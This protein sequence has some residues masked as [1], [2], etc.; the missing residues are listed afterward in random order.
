MKRF[1]KSSLSLLL[2]ITI[3]FSSAYVGLA[4]VDFNRES[5]YAGA[6]ELLFDV[7][8]I[9]AKLK[10][11]NL[12][13]SFSYQGF[14][15]IDFRG[16][17]KLGF[18]EGFAVKAKAADYSSLSPNEYMSKVILNY[19]YSGVLNEYGSLNRTPQQQII[20]DIYYIPSNASSARIFY[21]EFKNAEGFQ[22]TKFLYQALTFDPGNAVAQE[23]K[24][25][26][27]YSAIILSILDAKFQ[28]DNFIDSINCKTNKNILS[29]TKSV[30]NILKANS[31]YDVS[32]LSKIPISMLTED[33]VSY[34]AKELANSVN[35][36][37]LYKEIG[38]NL[39]WISDIIYAANSVNDA[40][41]SICAYTSLADTSVAVENVLYEIYLNSPS[42]TALRTAAGQ[43]YQYVSKQMT[44]DVLAM[45]T[46]KEAA[47][48]VATKM[49]LSSLWSKLWTSVPWGIGVTVGQAAGKM[50]ANY[51]FATDA[52][53]EQLLVLG[54]VV[55]FENVMISTVKSLANDYKNNPTERNADNYIKS[56][57][58]LLS[59]Y[60][61]GHIYSRDFM[62]TVY[63]SGA[64]SKI[65]YSG[66]GVLQDYL[67][68]SNARQANMPWYL[69]RFPHYAPFYEKDASS[70]YDDYFGGSYDEGAD[71]IKAEYMTLN[72]TSVELALNT[73]DTLVATVYPSSVSCEDSI[74][75]TSSNE[76]VV[77]V[78]LIE[79]ILTP[80]GPGT[81][82]IMVIGPDVVIATCKVTVLPFRLLKNDS[83]F[84]ISQYVGNASKVNIPSYISNFYINSIGDS[85]FENCYSI[86]S[87]I[88]PDSVTSIGVSAFANCTRLESITIPGN[89]TKLNDSTFRS[90]T[91]LTYVTIPDN[92]TS[93]GANAFRGCTNLNSITIP[94]NVSSI[95]DF[96]FRDC[97]YIENV[98]WNAKNV[99]DFDFESDI[100]CNAGTLAQGINLVFGDAVEKI[101]AYLCY[102]KNTC[103]YKTN[104]KSVTIGINVKSIG[105]DSFSGCEYLEKVY[106]NAK[107]V[108]DFDYCS[109]I[110]YNSGKLGSGI[111]II[112]GDNVERIPAYLCC[113]S[114]SSSYYPNIKSITIGESVTSIGDSAFE[115]CISL[116]KVYWNAK[117]VD[118]FNFQSNLFYNSGTSSSG[119]DIVFGDNV[120]RIPNYLCYVY[121]S[122]CR[123]NITSVTIGNGVTSIGNYA[124][125]NCT[126]LVSLSIGN[127]VNNIGERAFYECTSLTS[128]T[129]PNSLKTIG[130]SA[131]YGCKSLN[132]VYIDDLDAWFSIEFND[133]PLEYAGNLHL[134][135][136][137][138]SHIDIPTNLTEIPRNVFMGCTSLKTVAVHESINRIGENAFSSCT[139]LSNIS[140]PDGLKYIGDGAFSECISL[141]NIF[142]PES[143][144][145]IGEGAFGSCDSLKSIDIGSNI[146]EIGLGAF[147]RC[148]SL[149]SINVSVENQYFSSKDGVL[150]NKDQTVLICYPSGKINK[151]YTVP[152]S[153]KEIDYA[154]FLENGY[155]E[156]VSIP[157]NVISMGYASF[158]ECQNLKSVDIGDGLSELPGA[159]F[160][161]CF[162]LT[163]IDWGSNIK[164]IG[165]YAFDCCKNLVSI[166]IPDSVISIGEGT[167]ASC[168]NLSEVYLSDNLTTISNELFWY[169]ENLKTIV[170][171]N[172]VTNIGERAFYECTSLE[173]ITIPDSITNIDYCAFDYCYKLNDVFYLGVL[174]DW[175]NINIDSGN[176][177]LNNANISHL[178]TYGDWVVNLEP[179]CTQNGLRSKSCFVCGKT[180]T[181]T[182]T[183]LGHNYS[184]EWTIDIAPTCTED[185]SKSHHC[186]ACDDKTDIT[187]IEATGHNY[188]AQ[189]TDSN[190][191]HTI[192]YKCS[193]CED[194]KEETPVVPGCVECI[195]EIKDLVQ[196]TINTEIDYTDFVIRTNVETADEISDV[197]SL[198]ENTTVT[199]TPSY[200]YGDTEF[201]GTGTII[202]VF[203]GND[204]VGDFT[205]VVNGDTNG[206]SVCD[207][208]D[209]AQVALVSN[210][211]KTI[212]GAYKMAADS[213]SDDIVDIDDYQ[214]IVN[215][216]VS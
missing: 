9:S 127:N 91:S 46:A 115:E 125:G 106:W 179:N 176:G 200:K 68:S 59:T 50:I 155:I 150:F 30:T 119:I 130:R 184:T 131:F 186:I 54:C 2:A 75:F 195:N 61:L 212:D 25:E 178:C 196:E 157:D 138:V 33:E 165:E 183:H 128:I 134:N 121:D 140:I 23:M 43:V 41:K 205:L 100:L 189:S 144:S 114:N 145:F 53:L 95:G 181:E 120:E 40:I 194:I 93:I 147:C 21:D 202:T 87:V 11:L 206:D 188:V 63:T 82:E 122:S 197:L 102:G 85:A 36:K 34:I 105:A 116:E 16:F 81:A 170:I 158:G 86:K 60:E 156:Y 154:A 8:D 111:D 139:S 6:N 3:I 142:I 190:H 137:L 172:K 56:L 13:N 42:N 72:K 69:I 191:P 107:N 70:G 94:K 129:I 168:T 174:S 171:P 164:T 169:C 201:F 32:N 193:V 78:D 66:D 153:V 152:S 35:H 27:Y 22:T 51:C 47:N 76:S 161:C 151:N 90:C 12:N 146:R 39:S 52:K 55:D 175:G 97:K 133:N 166:S 182:I 187:V 213:N 15:N 83:G 98:Y 20:E 24:Q 74:S 198:S 79:G 207:A 162:N 99:V 110:F 89:I 214:A 112:F 19:N 10:E 65:L 1:L 18:G 143:V 49:L 5:S 77:K 216:A 37:N 38:G 4:E 31:S 210:G 163:S 180:T 215:K 136:K 14:N 29:A 211:H 64:V 132:A 126:Y 88:V 159:T 203:D 96:A 167:F 45:I 123:P 124:F 48:E 185:G 84:A 58:F 7:E 92:V 108:S 209:A 67:D 118:D 208:L 71:R 113:H 135:G 160:L 57:E 104:I 28:D 73:R 149:G 192:T 103:S 101:P 177:Y 17:S 44:D 148:S 204:Y 199:I 80:V 117:C 26:D 62:T 141:S 173:S 109:D